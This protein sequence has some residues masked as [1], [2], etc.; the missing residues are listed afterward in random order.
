MNVY[1]CG[2]SV[3]DDRPY[4][5]FTKTKNRQNDWLAIGAGVE[6]RLPA[7]AIPPLASIV[8]DHPEATH[9]D[10]Y[11]DGGLGGLFSQRFVNAV[12][13]E[14]LRCFVLI[15]ALLNGEIYFFLRCEHPVDCLDHSKSEYKGFPHDPTSIMQIMHHAF[16]E[17]RIPDGLFCIPVS[18]R[19]LA[20][21]AVVRRIK[22]AGL[23]GVATPPLP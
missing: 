1:D 15:P 13:A 12:G 2:P 6:H 16:F 7:A 18:K 3:E 22:K 14:A 10:C 9:W 19:L 8:V 4:I 21:H 5:D 20:T 17:E 23:K 11:R